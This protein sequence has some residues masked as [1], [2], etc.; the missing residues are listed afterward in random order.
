MPQEDRG[1]RGVQCLCVAWFGEASPWGLRGHM[2]ALRVSMPPGS[3]R[4][5]ALLRPGHG[6]GGH[7][8][9]PAKIV[10]PGG[11][12]IVAPDV[13]TGRFGMGLEQDML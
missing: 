1:S 3:G 11:A 8:L 12:K 10:A 13:D 2:L 7:D 6:R 5:F 4:A 9:R